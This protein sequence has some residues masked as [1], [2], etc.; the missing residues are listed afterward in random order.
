MEG[1]V[2]TVTFGVS[3]QMAEVKHAL[4]D[5]M[6]TGFWLVLQN[7][8]LAETWDQELIDLLKVGRLE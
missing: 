6:Q 3:T 7:T 8:H 1:R 5:C 2:H 4:K